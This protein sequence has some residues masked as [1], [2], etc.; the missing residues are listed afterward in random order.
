MFILAIVGSSRLNG[1]TSYLADQALAEAAGLGADTGKISLSEYIVGP[2]L[3]HANCSQFDSCARNDD[4]ARILDDFC[5]ADAVILATPVYYYDVSAWMK[6]FIDR[7]WFLR[8]H[9]LKCRARAVGIIVVG[10]GSGIDETVGT[11]KRFV[12]S[13]SFGS[14]ALNKRFVVSGCADGPAE[15]KN[16]QRLVNGAR[17]MGRKLVESLRD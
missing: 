4:G 14:L 9:G 3:V 1:N 7:N 8:Q 15:V 10:G 5:K 13:S 16:D 2:C 6:T 11:M 12:N 17:D